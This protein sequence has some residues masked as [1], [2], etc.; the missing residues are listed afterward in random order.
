MLASNNDR[1]CRRPRTRDTLSR[2][3]LRQTASVPRT[4]DLDDANLDNRSLLSTRPLLPTTFFPVRVL[5]I[6]SPDARARRPP[7]DVL[8][9]LFPRPLLLL[10]SFFPSHLHA[11]QVLAVLVAEDVA[12][13]V[14]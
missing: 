12:R 3:H 14:T 1:S 11:R 10:L 13:G 8:L 6:I 5:I 4:R 9:L 2:L 7:D